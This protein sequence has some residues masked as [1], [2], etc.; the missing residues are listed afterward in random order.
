[1]S[2]LE[3]LGIKKS[4]DQ[5]MWDLAQK[6]SDLHNDGMPDEDLQKI[7][8]IECSKLG[9]K[10]DELDER[11]QIVRAKPIRLNFIMGWSQFTPTPDRLE[12]GECCT[13]PMKSG[14]TGIYKKINEEWVSGVDWNWHDIIF[15]G[16]KYGNRKVCKDTEITWV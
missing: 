6:I 11:Y 5:K 3:T 1:M 16:Y 7:L 13:A 15:V 12:V 14:H 2:L 9:I 4:K 10:E 8:D